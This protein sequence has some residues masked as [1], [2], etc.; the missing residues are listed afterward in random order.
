MLSQLLSRTIEYKYKNLLSPILNARIV[1]ILKQSCEIKYYLIL[2][3]SD[4]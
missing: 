4:K 3:Y 1:L 2:G